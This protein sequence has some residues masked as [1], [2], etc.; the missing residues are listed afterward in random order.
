[1]DDTIENVQTKVDKYM[2]QLF[3]SARAH[4]NASIT[5]VDDVA[6]AI[7]DAYGDIVQAVHRL[8][9]IDLTKAEQLHEIA[10]L[11]EDLGMKRRLILEAEKQLID[12]NARIDHAIRGITEPALSRARK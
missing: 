10:T 3:E 4:S 11:T 12:T 7:T 6:R 8:D 9:D 1:M 2:L 5:P